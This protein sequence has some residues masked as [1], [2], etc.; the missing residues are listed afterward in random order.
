[1]PQFIEQV[2]KSVL[3]KKKFI[4]LPKG[5]RH[6]T[7]TLL[8]LPPPHENRLLISVGS[9]CNVCVEQDWRYASITCRKPRELCL[10]INRDAAQRESGQA[11]SPH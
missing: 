9:D 11:M 3:N 4:D 2:F 7:R 6:F 10:T 5:G 8:F 1:M